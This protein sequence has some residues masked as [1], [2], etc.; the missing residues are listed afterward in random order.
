M[1]MN[2]IG[3]QLT[4]QGSGVF[5]PSL[6]SPGGV[7][8][9]WNVRSQSHFLHSVQYARDDMLVEPIMFWDVVFSNIKDEGIERK[10]DQSRST[11]L[12]YS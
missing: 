2:G 8:N 1:I 10:R 6:G 7:L 9:T 5:Q 11:Q 3:R 4:S 12:I